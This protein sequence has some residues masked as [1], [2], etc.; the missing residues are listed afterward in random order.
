MGDKRTEEL[1]TQY[2]EAVVALFMDEY[3]QEHGKQLLA[4]FEEAQKNG[5]IPKISDELDRKCR[6]QIQKHFRQ[7]RRLQRRK[8][9]IRKVGQMAAAFLLVICLSATLVMSVDAFRVPVVN[10][11]LSQRGHSNIAGFDDPK[12]SQPADCTET[13]DLETPLAGLLPN[14]YSCAKYSFEYN[15][16]TYFCCYSNKEGDLVSLQTEIGNGMLVYDSENAEIK[17]FRVMGYDGVLIE[18]GDSKLIWYVPEENLTYQ[19]RATVLSLD[20]VWQI[21]EEIVKKDMEG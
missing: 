18:K 16:G 6:D 7:R 8:Q 3:A 10:F 19:L 21:A 12:A 14:D 1:R 4:E 17:P 13:I 5:A 15:S 2:E 9:L 20:E 11:L